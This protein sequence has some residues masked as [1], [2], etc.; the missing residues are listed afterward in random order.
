MSQA[1]AMRGPILGRVRRDPRVARHA[2]D[3]Q[4]SEAAPAECAGIDAEAAPVIAYAGGVLCLCGDVVADQW[5]AIGF[6][7][8]MAGPDR[9]VLAVAATP[10]DDRAQAGA[11]AAWMLDLARDGAVDDLATTVRALALGAVVAADGGASGHAAR[12]LAARLGWRLA[13][14]VVAAREGTIIRLVDGGRNECE[15]P[16]PQVVVLAPGQGAAARAPRPTC[17]AFQP[18][19]RADTPSR[20]LLRDLGPVRQDPMDM[21]LGEARVVLAGGG[22]LTAW[23]DLA[24]VALRLDAAIGASRVA[25]DRGSAARHRQVG[26]SGTLVG[27]RVYV[28]FGVSG[29]IQHLQG[30]ERCARVVAINTDPEA[31]ISGRADLT[32]VADADATVRALRARIEAAA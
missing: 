20:A 11:D 5:M 16:S 10:A 23:S 4:A 9:A 17:I 2:P 28:A 3:R 12:A 18:S 31:P 32:I 29:A 30:I 6:A 21:P 7:R 24:A 1:D 19:H 13:A 25:C 15:E 14:N 8:L 26:A 22:G 27:A